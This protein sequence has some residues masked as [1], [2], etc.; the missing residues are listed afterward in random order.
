MFSGCLWPSF[1]LFHCFLFVFFGSHATREQKQI[2]RRTTTK[3]GHSNNN[4]GGLSERTRGIES[5]AQCVKEMAVALAKRQIGIKNLYF[6][7]PGEF[8]GP[9]MLQQVS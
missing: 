6:F 7:P 2:K 8:S 1:Q 3:V 4:T 5:G 9:L